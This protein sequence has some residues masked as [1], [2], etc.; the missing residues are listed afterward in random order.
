M[1]LMGWSAMR[2]STSE[3]GFRVEAV[4]PGG[5]DQGVRRPPLLPR[6]QACLLPEIPRWYD[7]ER[8]TK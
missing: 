3:P 4:E 2:V 1:R 8:Q 7:A 6:M 5:F